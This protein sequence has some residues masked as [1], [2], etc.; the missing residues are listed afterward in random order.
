MTGQFN[1]Y[2]DLDIVREA[3]L[4]YR[5]QWVWWLSAEHSSDAE[6][7]LA[8]MKLAVIDRALDVTLNPPGAGK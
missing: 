4:N 2:N 5:H 3:L 1:C 8:R 6:R 7:E